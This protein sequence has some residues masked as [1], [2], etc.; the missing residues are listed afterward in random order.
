MKTDTKLTI[1]SVLLVVIVCLVLWKDE[2]FKPKPEPLY[3]YTV[4]I[5]DTKGDTVF[6]KVITSVKKLPI[7][8]IR[9]ELVNDK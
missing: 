6:N 5:T 2:I 1:V 3:Q 9:M 7:D 8:T 4:I